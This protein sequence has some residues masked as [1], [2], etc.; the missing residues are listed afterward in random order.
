MYILGIGERGKG[1]GDRG[2]G[3]GLDKSKIKSQK[4]LNFVGASLPVG[5]FELFCPR[6]PIPNPQSLIAIIFL[7]PSQ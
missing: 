5:Y 6:S 1:K 4:I 2:K 7:F 3:K